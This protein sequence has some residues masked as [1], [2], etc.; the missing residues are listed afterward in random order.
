MAPGCLGAYVG[1]ADPEVQQ[2]VLKEKQHGKL[3]NGEESGLP[4]DYWRNTVP[5]TKEEYVNAVPP[6][7]TDAAITHK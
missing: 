4:S 6:A 3:I 5:L 1:L 7:P 2:Q